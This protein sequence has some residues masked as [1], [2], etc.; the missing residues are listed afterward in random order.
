MDY[1]ILFLGKLFPREKE[2]E[3]KQKMNTGMQ[4]AANALQWN[5]IDG[6]D[7]NH[8]GTIKILDYLPVDSYPKG[9]CDKTIPEYVFQHSDR[10]VS[11]DKIVKCTNLT[12][13]KQF[14]NLAP[15]QKEVRKWAEDRSGKKKI[16]IC[17]TA[18]SMF[19]SLLK[20]AKKCNSD[21]V[22]ACVIADLPEFISARTL[23]GIR[24]RYNDY[25]KRHSD[26]LYPYVDKFILLTK[27]MA[28]RLNIQ[29]PF[30]VMEGIA[31]MTDCAQDPS[32][33]EKYASDKYI[34]YSGTLN[35]SFG[36]K[37]LLEAFSMVSEEHLKLII[38]GFGEAEEEIRERM[39][40]D[41]RITFLGK[42]DR[43]Q[44]LPLQRNAT[45]LVNPRQNTEEFTKYSFPSKN[46]EYLSSGVPV[47]AY[48][49]DG[50][51]DEYDPY[52][53]YPKDN[54]SEELSRVI[55]QISEMDPDQ[56]KQMGRE[57]QKFVLEN[58]NNVVQTKRI[59]EFLGQ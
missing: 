9:Y 7:E 58:K 54:T 4:D 35:Y 37:T 47:I 25:E 38:C 50:I 43:K 31:T 14:C 48:K 49:L 57:A 1:D 24:K 36:I 2:A 52:I 11:N 17:Y 42:L 45:V 53:H 51:P 20:F 27:H 32:V 44:V 21:I 28:A 18:S 41:G 23:S 26:R 55:G 13:V 19:L 3:I 6:M 56:R 39:K 29:A 30:L 22:S 59:L 46:L 12:I 15:F 5:L 16:L 40:N 33:V 8:C 34:F 10:Y